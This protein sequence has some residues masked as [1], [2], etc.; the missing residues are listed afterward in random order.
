MLL[1]SLLSFVDCTTYEW[2][3]KR[4]TMPESFWREIG[5]SAGVAHVPWSF[6]GPG[7]KLQ[8]IVLAKPDSQSIKLPEQV[9]EKY[10]RREEP[11]L[12]L[13]KRQ[14]HRLVI[15]DVC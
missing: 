15:V 1:P 13:C 14:S 10:K 12:V 2:E 5:A 6:F 8:H 7:V 4:A 11:R 9:I 3:L